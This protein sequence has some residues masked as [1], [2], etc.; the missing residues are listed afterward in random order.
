[1]CLAGCPVLWVNKL[2][3]EIAL[4]TMES[5]YLAVSTACKDLLPIVDLVK[6]IGTVFGLP[7]GN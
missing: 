5:E 2:Q 6:E 1:M 7:V 4:S 3:T